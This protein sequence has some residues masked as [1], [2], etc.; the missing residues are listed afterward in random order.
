MG[1]E[2]DTNQWLDASHWLPAGAPEA[3][4]SSIGRGDMHESRMH[5]GPYLLPQSWKAWRS[6]APWRTLRLGLPGPP[7]PG[8]LATVE[9]M[10]I[11]LRV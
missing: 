3:C 6:S 11:C 9:N 7:T 10:M 4:R 5:T 8:V 2:L 1:R